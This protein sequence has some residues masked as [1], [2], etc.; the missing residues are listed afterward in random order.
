MKTLKARITFIEEVLGTASNNPEIHRECIANKAAELSKSNEEVEA[1]DVA[2]P[3][4]KSITVFPRNEN[5]KPMYWDY[6]IKGFF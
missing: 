4:E 1:I 6:Q 5:G 3:I 2:E